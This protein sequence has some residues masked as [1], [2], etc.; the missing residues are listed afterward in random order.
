[1]ERSHRWWCYGRVASLQTVSETLVKNEGEKNVPLLR[2]VAKLGRGL[3]LSGSA[4]GLV[5]IGELPG[6]LSDSF[7]AANPKGA[8]G[9]GSE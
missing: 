8:G 9:N 6:G 2:N 3:T 1:V 4:P 5:K 7:E